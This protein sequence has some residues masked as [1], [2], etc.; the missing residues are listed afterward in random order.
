MH[1]ITSLLYKIKNTK[2]NQINLFGDGTPLRQFMYAGD[3]ARIIKRTIDENITDS[4]NIAYPE[5]MSI[6]EMA[7]RTLNALGKPYQIAYSNPNLNGQIRKD[8]SIEKFKTIFPDFQFT[9]FE[10]GV[11]KVYD[12]INQQ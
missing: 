12:K 1:F 10:E 4:F 6:D 5:N 9:S 2:D 3:L 7:K 11:R 8:V